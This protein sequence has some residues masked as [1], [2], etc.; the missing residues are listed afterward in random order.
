M[1][2]RGQ[3]V[4]SALIPMSVPA[5]KEKHHDSH[6]QRLKHQLATVNE[7]S[8]AS[9]KFLPLFLSLFHFLP[10]HFSSNTVQISTLGDLRDRRKKET[11]RDD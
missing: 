8:L 9:V 11:Y 5:G 10:S 6:S 3:N 7:A 4:G 1:N 2:V